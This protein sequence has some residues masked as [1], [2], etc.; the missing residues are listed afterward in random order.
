MTFQKVPYTID[1]LDESIRAIAGDFAVRLDDTSWARTSAV[2]AAAGKAWIECYPEDQHTAIL[3][4]A[5]LD[6]NKKA[7]F[8]PVDGIWPD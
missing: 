5:A 7:R 4:S 6:L 3:R 2:L 1:Q 8:D